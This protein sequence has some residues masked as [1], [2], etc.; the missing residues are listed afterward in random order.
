[1]SVTILSCEDES[2]PPDEHPNCLVS[3]AEDGKNIF[4]L[5]PHSILTLLR[6]VR[7]KP[8]SKSKTRPGRAS[9]RSL[10]S[11]QAFR[12]DRYLLRRLAVL[13]RNTTPLIEHY[14]LSNHLLTSDDEAI[15]VSVISAPRPNPA[16]QTQQAH[17]PSIRRITPFLSD[18]VTAVIDKQVSQYPLQITS[19]E[20]ALSPGFCVPTIL[21]TPP[22]DNE[23]DVL[24]WIGWNIIP[25]PQNSA[26]GV[27]LTVPGI[28]SPC[29]ATDWRAQQRSA[30]SQIPD[31]CSEFGNLTTPSQSI[32]AMELGI[33]ELVR[34]HAYFQEAIDDDE[35]DGTIDLGP[36]WSG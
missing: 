6:K 14:S 19:E 11:I 22:S 15:G 26:D 24:S 34:S 4:P 5:L 9:L 25:M 31:R 2:D 32:A 3:P 8:S 13:W 1:M 16:V 17:A 30:T 35:D 36:T 21:I 33:K 27:L 29:S 7:V 23:E 10:V 20:K 28:V 18:P 12:D